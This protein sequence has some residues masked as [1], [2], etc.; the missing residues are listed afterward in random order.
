MSDSRRP[1]GLWVV[2][3]V[4]GRNGG[5]QREGPRTLR[6]AAAWTRTGARASPSTATAS[7]RTLRPAEG[8]ECLGKS[9]RLGQLGAPELS[10]RESQ[11]LARRWLS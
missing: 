4:R 9:P 8:A 5:G 11:G 7:P 10:I 1:P 3:V 6:V 2:G